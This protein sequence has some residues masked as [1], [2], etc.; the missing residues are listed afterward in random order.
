GGNEQVGY[1]DRAASAVASAAP[2]RQRLKLAALAGSGLHNRRDLRE[3]RADAGRNAR[4]NGA[5]SDGHETRH[6]SIFDE[7]LTARIL[8]NL[9]LQNEVLH[10]LN[11]SS[12][13][14]ARQ[15]SAAES[16]LSSVHCR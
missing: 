6:Q 7:V 13:Y 12:P 1:A 11:L 14:G 3:D 16:K 5:G 15:V 2:I 9:Q 4:H 8:P 10:F